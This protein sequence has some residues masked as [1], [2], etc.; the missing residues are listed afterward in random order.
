MLADERLDIRIGTYL[1]G[2][3]MH[4]RR[5]DH[6]FTKGLHSFTD[7]LFIVAR[8]ELFFPIAFSCIEEGTAEVMSLSDCLDA[9]IML[10]SCTIAM[11]EAHASHSYW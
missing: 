1:F 2:I 7:E 6:I 11:G 4:L 8:V 9:V 10:R 5:Y 3:E